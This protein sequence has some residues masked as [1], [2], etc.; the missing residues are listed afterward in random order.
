MSYTYAYKSYKLQ[1][2]MQDQGILI[3]VSFNKYF[4]YF[5]YNCNIYDSTN[6]KSNL[7][8]KKIKWFNL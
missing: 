2:I 5:D 4:M 6:K 7:Q 1:L 3:T 8:L